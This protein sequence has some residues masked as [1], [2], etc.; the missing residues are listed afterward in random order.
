MHTL[1]EKHLKY[2]NHP[3]INDTAIEVF[4]YAF[5]SSMLKFLKT[6]LTSSLLMAPSGKASH[7]RVHLVSVNDPATDEENIKHFKNQ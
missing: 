4:L 2:H 5:D 1:R 6:L 3:A 7:I